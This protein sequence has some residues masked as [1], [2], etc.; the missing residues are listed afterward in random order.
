MAISHPQQRLRAPSRSL[1]LALH[2]AGIVSFLLSFRFLYTWETPLSNTYGGNYQFLTIIGLAL[3]LITFSVGLLSDVT[4]SPTLF[5]LK[6]YLAIV[7]APLEILITT[8]YWGLCAIDRS[9]V[10]P[11]EFA[12]DI[13]PDIGFHAAPGVFLALDLLLFSPPWTIQRNNALVLSLA[14]T[15]GYWSWV[16]YCYGINGWYGFLYLCWDEY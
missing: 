6:N 3:S 9:L 4:L 2:A 12:L 11:P 14:F 16:E 13:I 1:S 15:F 5:R 10:F 7:S 8:L